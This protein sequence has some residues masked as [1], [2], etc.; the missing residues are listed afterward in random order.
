MHI[1]N[2]IY[3]FQMKRIS[4]KSE[5][6]FLGMIISLPFLDFP[7]FEIGF[8]LQLSYVFA[9][10]TLW[11]TLRRKEMRVFGPEFLI[12]PLT[13]PLAIF[14]TF[15]FLSIFQS[16]FIPPGQRF[17]AHVN[18]EFF[19]HKPFIR[20]LAQFTA[21]LF[22]ALPFF[23]SVNFIKTKTMLYK[24]V[25]VWMFANSLASLYGLFGFWGSYVPNFPFANSVVMSGYGGFM[26]NRI[27]STG[28][29]P[30]IFGLSLVI[31]LP[32]AISV[33][34]ARKKNWLILLIIPQL[35]ALLLTFS[36][37]AWLAL[38]IA[39]FALSFLFIKQIIRHKLKILIGTA[40][41]CI[42]FEFIFLAA[43]KYSGLV[44]VFNRFLS[45]L[46]G[47][48]DYSYLMRY[49]TGLTALRIFKEHFILGGGIGN[50]WFYY[51][52]YSPRLL[53]DWWIKSGM[54]PPTVNNIFL[55]FLA[56]TGILGFAALVYFLFVLF[57]TVI[58]SI[59]KTKDNESRIILFGVLASLAAVIV[60]Y[61]L[62][63][64]FYFTFIWVLFGIAIAASRISQGV[65][66]DGLENREITNRSQKS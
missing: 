45:S 14:L 40:L 20:S 31:P 59:R 23:L 5:Y 44:Y 15:I 17:L 48:S 66:K 54:I 53:G 49:E 25:V 62:I 22:M 32:M 29:E 37:G 63:S 42:V 8:T 10:L 16:R 60:G 50:F 13:L 3:K 61:Q 65:A 39:L 33:A 64:T 52:Q 36:R 9:I 51:N 26:V 2:L 34:V 7:V 43:F 41:F 30:L 27:K 21:L 18:V 38:L 56:E 6:L 11:L 35:L 46:E 55:S 12:T 57:K 24:V 47:K 58:T 28:M 1:K 19:V 4:L